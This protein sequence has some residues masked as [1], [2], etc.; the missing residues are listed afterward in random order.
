MQW[1][2]PPFVSTRWANS[3]RLFNL[4]GIMFLVRL[5]LSRRLN[6]AA[7][8]DP[9]PL[10]LYEGQFTQNTRETIGQNVTNCTESDP[11]LRDK[12]R[13]KEEEER[14]LTD[15]VFHYSTH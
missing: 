15:T 5:T 4:L 10:G 9:N 11:K 2:Q 6:P 14:H 8:F 12:N 13:L 7:K 3:L 1:M